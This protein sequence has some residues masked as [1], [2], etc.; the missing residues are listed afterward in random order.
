MIVKYNEI[1]RKIIIILILFLVLL[2]THLS[3]ANGYK[4]DIVIKETGGLKRNPGFITL[5]VEDPNLSGDDCILV[6][7][8]TKKEIPFH[9]VDK[10]KG[11]IRIRFKLNL[12]KGEEKNLEF[13]FSTGEKR[14]ILP[15]K[16]FSFVDYIGT[17]F[18]GISFEKIY[19]IALKDSDV[20]VTNKDGKLLFSGKIKYG[21]YERIDL[22]SP[23]SFHVVSTGPLMVTVSSIGKPGK[24]MPE[25]KSDDDIM[26]IIGTEGFFFTHSDIFVT[27]LFDNNSVRVEDSGGDLIYKGTLKAGETIKKMGLYP[28]LLY[29]KADKPILIQYGKFDDSAFT[30]IV[31]YLGFLYGYSFGELG[32]FSFENNTSVLFKGGGKTE[33]FSLKSKEFK[34]IDY[35]GSFEI[36]AD[37]PILVYSL[38][39]SSNFGGEEIPTLLGYASSTKFDFVTGKI[40]FKYSKGHRRL[41]SVL[42]QVG[43]NSIEIKG[44]VIKSI[45]ATLPSLGIAQAETDKTT[46]LI[47]VSSK[48]PVMVFETSNHTNREIFFN[49]IPVADKSIIITI[50]ETVPVSSTTPVT[51]VKP[52]KPTPPKKPELKLPEGLVGKVLWEFNLLPDRFRSFVENVKILPSLLKIGNLPKVSIPISFKLPKINLVLPE[53]LVP[54]MDKI[55]PY[56]P[57]FLQGFNFILLILLLL[58][59]LLVLIIIFI[60]VRKKKK[61][62]I[63]TTK[64]EAVIEEPEIN[65]EEIEPKIIKPE[66]SLEV[67]TEEAEMEKKEEETKEEE[68]VEVKAEEKISP[69]VKPE[70]EK[71]E[72]EEVKEEAK[73][74]ETKPEGGGIED[75]FAFG[76][77]TSDT[78]PGDLEELLPSEITPSQ[79]EIIPHSVVPEE[80]FDVSILKGK[81]VLDRK[82]LLR[83]IELDLFPFLEEAYVTEETIKDLPLKFRT[84]SKLKSVELTKFEKSM[85]EDLGKRVGGS[86]ETGEAIALALK[87]KIDKCIVGEKFNKNFQNIR[88]IS[89]E[90]L[91]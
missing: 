87:L 43:N 81:I 51:P 91:K 66:E 52:Q 86:P 44:Q 71:V 40:S 17:E 36:N 56:L 80:E 49:L 15:E 2:P 62:G 90:N 11:K 89:Y 45:R 42:S 64:K 1:V 82:A 33:K 6:D 5:T 67:S 79:E 72:K 46:S 41:I 58:L 74:E 77:E 13:R 73:G 28:S 53:F 70:E 57:S 27:S 55:N 24:N 84:S 10:E 76:P 54:V 39:K 19:L 20:K 32:I 60:V 37:K 78:S 50:G 59:L 30:V 18:Y 7:K 88:I 29:Y 8:D 75:L 63:M 69:E 3:A 68:I 47:N 34:L 48:N 83:I 12:N 16:D 22:A 21:H 25:D 31:P 14:S 35:K 4:K 9:I 23:Q 61:V 26:S 85:A 38:G 65:P